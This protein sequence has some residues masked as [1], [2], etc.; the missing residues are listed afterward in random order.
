MT[1]HSGDD[2]NPERDA[3]ICDLLD[4][5]AQ[6]RL[7]ELF[8]RGGLRMGRIQST[9]DLSRPSRLEGARAR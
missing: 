7:S 9:Q 8:G 3:F 6:I 2:L 5:A 1:V 4:R